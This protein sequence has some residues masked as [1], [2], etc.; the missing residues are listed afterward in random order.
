MANQWNYNR[1]VIIKLQ[2]ANDI[3][4]LTSTAYLPLFVRLLVSADR[5]GYWENVHFWCC[6]YDC[7]CVC[8]CEGMFGVGMD[9]GSM[10]LPIRPQRYCDPHV[11]SYLCFC[12][13]SCM[14]TR[15]SRPIMCDV[16]IVK[17]MRYRPTDRVCVRVCVFVCPFKPFGDVG[18]YQGKMY[19]TR[20]DGRIYT[21]AFHSQ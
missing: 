7:L 10:P 13:L 9:G 17:Q 2:Y 3:L 5:V 21:P 19:A 12:F 1:A 20:Q 6:R 18:R 11:T 4:T 15:P 16:W 8:V 14:R